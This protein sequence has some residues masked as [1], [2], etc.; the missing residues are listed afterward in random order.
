MK[1]VH[2]FENM[3]QIQLMANLTRYRILYLLA[4]KAMT[5]SQLARVLKIPRQ[6]AHYHLKLLVEGGLV[7]LEKETIHEGKVE[8]YYLAIAKNFSAGAILGVE[9][10]QS[11]GPSI[12]RKKAESIRDVSMAF[13][14]QAQSD[15]E[16]TNAIEKMER[17][18]LPF[19][20]KGSLTPEQETIMAEKLYA[21]YNEINELTAQNLEKNEHI[22]LLDVRYTL[23]L[24]PVESSLEPEE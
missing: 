1:E 17:F 2:V 10:R 15:L 13:L 12:L 5:G 8:K 16:Q 9:K 22:T 21:I 3:E 24:T 4:Q 11:D 23:L 20:M 14:Q 7:V 19:Q 6:L 18:H